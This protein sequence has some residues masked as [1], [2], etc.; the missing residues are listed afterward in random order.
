MSRL[1]DHMMGLHRELDE[2]LF[3]HQQALLDR[4]VAAAARAL[5]HCRELLALHMADEEEFVLPRYALGGGDATDAPVRL[6]LGEHQRVREFLDRFA[7]A[8]AAMSS[9]PDDRRLLE[10]LDLQATFKN[11]LLHHDLRERNALYPR[12]AA[13]LTAQDETALLGRLR[14][15]PS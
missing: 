14:V 7:V 15:Q 9:P 5:A 4:D 13:M 3:V 6:F 12:L 11:L 8:L 1:Q 2:R 10:L